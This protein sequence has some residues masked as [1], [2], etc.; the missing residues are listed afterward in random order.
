MLPEAFVSASGQI[1][2]EEKAIGFLSPEDPNTG[3]MRY[4][5][6]EKKV[7]SE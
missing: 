7:I 6:I 1:R 2:K 4:P 5:E 3:G